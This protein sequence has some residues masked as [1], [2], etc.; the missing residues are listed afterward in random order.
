[1][2]NAI[3]NPF[4]MFFDE[5]GLPLD[6]GYLFVGVAGLNPPSNPQA[7]Y[8][9]EA[10]TIPAAGVRI[11]GGFIINNGKPSVVYAAGDYSILIKNK[12]DKVL[13]SSLNST[14]NDASQF[15]TELRGGTTRSMR[16][17]P[18]FNFNLIVESGY[19]SWSNVGTVNYPATGV[20]AGDLFAL[21]V[22]SSPDGAGIIF[23]RIMD[24][25]NGPSSLYYFF[26]RQSLDGGATWTAWQVMPGPMGA[27]W[28]SLV[29][30]AVGAGWTSLMQL[31]A[32]SIFNSASIIVADATLV[33]S[34]VNI[35]NK[36]AYG[37][38][39][40]LILPV[41][42]AGDRLKLKCMSAAKIVQNDAEHV[43][44]WRNSLFTS[45]GVAGELKLD[46]GDDVD[47]TF[48]GSGFALA[49]PAKIANPATLPAALGDDVAWSHDG[50]FVAVGHV[51]TPFVTIYD[52]TSGVP[53]KIANPA[54]L[55]PAEGIKVCWSPDD[56][57]LAVIHNTTPFVT[58]YDFTSGAPVKIANPAILPTGNSFGGC[59]STSGK[60]LVV[61]HDI[62]PFVTIYDFTSGAPVKIANPAT[63]P[64][65]VGRGAVWSSDNRYLAIAHDT[66]PFVTIYDWISGV[67]IKIANP[68][69]LPPA[70]AMSAGWSPNGRY[71]IIGH[72]NSPYITIYDWV[73][74]LPVKITDPAVLPTG[75]GRGPTWSFDGR[76]LAVAHDTTPFVTIYDW[77]SGVPIKITNPATLPAGNAYGTDWSPDGRYLAVSHNASP[78]ITIYDRFVAASKTWLVE[79]TSRGMM[80]DDKGNILAFRFK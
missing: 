37:A 15:M 2:A 22:F 28:D 70:T 65:G 55:P 49:A 63:L 4:P 41:A 54:T 30:V 33:K 10:L 31:A 17:P 1:M 8:W 16:V 72:A 6:G 76:Y 38:R 11:S 3:K 18:S 73:S 52:F 68:A 9:D 47:L 44:N 24:L 36:P 79:I 5:D 61:T 64:T 7:I 62:T 29:L 45:K 46:P 39:S 48:L 21:E 67:P 34:A 13:Y 32:T 77:I 19:Y 42:N 40:A 35:I 14:V 71:L 56:K 50:R 80:K 60:Y 74:G 20:A 27:G 23:Q 66:T 58:I 53:V 26:T 59:W 57:Y 43:I 25:T 75:G 69:T 78:F 51:T 12:N